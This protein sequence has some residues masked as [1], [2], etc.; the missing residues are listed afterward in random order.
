VERSDLALE[1]IGAAGPR[2]ESEVADRGGDLEPHDE[3][4]LDASGG[5]RGQRRHGVDPE[6]P[7]VTLV[8]ER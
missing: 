7:A 3:V 1:A 5:E 2:G 4:G 8:G 6:A